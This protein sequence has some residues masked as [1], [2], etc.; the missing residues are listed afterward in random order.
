MLKEG[1]QCEECRKLPPG[2]GHWSDCSVH[3]EPADPNGPCDCTLYTDILSPEENL[4]RNKRI[5]AK[6]SGAD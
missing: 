6:E 4:E 3:S 2:I 5:K 1:C